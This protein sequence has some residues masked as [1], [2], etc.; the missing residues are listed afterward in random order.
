[1]DHLEFV[2][3]VRHGAQATNDDVGAHF[4]S[5]FDQQHLE[6]LH[7]DRGAVVAGQLCRFVFDDLDTLLKRE[8]WRLRRI[9]RHPDDEMI[10][11]LHRPADNVEMAERERIERTRIKSNAFLAHGQPPQALSPAASSMR[12]TDTTRSFSSTRKTV[13]P[14]AERPWIE[15]P[16]TG[17]RIVWP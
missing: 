5:E 13:T 6:R 15:M 17:T 2:L 9:G 4:L 12:S 8:Q 3:E 1:A 14:C 7:F 16:D 11:E 10:D